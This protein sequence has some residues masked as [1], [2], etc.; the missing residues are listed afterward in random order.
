MPTITSR[1]QHKTI[2]FVTIRCIAGVFAAGVYELIWCFISH[3]AEIKPNYKKCF[4]IIFITTTVGEE[5]S[6]RKGERF[7]N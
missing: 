6:K 4:I 7:E 3:K 5:Q 1:C 2:H